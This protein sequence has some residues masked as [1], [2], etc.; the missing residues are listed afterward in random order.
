MDDVLAA[1]MFVAMIVAVSIGAIGVVLLT[2]H[3]IRR[4][5]KRGVR[6]D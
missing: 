1:C 4:T 6:N 2:T 3:E 5:I